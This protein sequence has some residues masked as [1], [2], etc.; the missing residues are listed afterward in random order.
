[1]VALLA[2]VFCLVSQSGYAA[3]ANGKSAFDKP[4]LEAYLK[5]LLLVSPGVEI[6]VHDAKPSPV[7]GLKEVDVTLSFQGTSEERAYYVSD[8]GKWVLEAQVHNIAG[9]PFQT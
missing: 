4:T 7:P 9:S 3:G 1:V 8:D 5:H 2:G 6:K